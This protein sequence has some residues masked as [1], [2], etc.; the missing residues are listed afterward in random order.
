[1]P[2]AA[3]RREET[4]CSCWKCSWR[5][6][7]RPT[8]S[9]LALVALACLPRACLRCWSPAGS[10]ASRRRRLTSSPLRRLTGSRA[11]SVGTWTVCAPISGSGAERISERSQPP[12]SSASGR[13][14]GSGRSSD[15]TTGRSGPHSSAK[16]AW[17][18]AH[19]LHQ[20][21]G[22]LL[23]IR[24]VALDAAEE[25]RAER[26]QVGGRA[27]RRRQLPVLVHRVG[28]LRRP[29]LGDGAD[30]GDAVL[31]GPLLFERGPRA[32]PGRGVPPP[33]LGRA[34]RGPFRDD[35]TDLLGQRVVAAE[36]FLRRTGR[37]AAEH[38]ATVVADQHGARGDVAVGPAVGVQRAQRGEDVGGD[39]GGAVG[40]DGG[41]G[42]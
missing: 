14:S 13:S 16:A 25:Q 12:S 28:L 3:G 27:D 42:E 5:T 35:G 32:V 29:A 1:M 22:V 23:R 2:S 17:L 6:S 30:D 37:Q 26:P 41:F 38:G 8:R 21:G 7:L 15:S 31:P 36:G 33:A 11:G 9:R 24:R 4:T 40:V 34:F 20:L 39:L 19:K 18:G 10:A